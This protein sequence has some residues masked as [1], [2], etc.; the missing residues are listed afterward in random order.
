MSEIE[1]VIQAF[2][3]DVVTVNLAHTT[4]GVINVV[5]GKL[6]TY[7]LFAAPAVAAAKPFLRGAALQNAEHGDLPQVREGSQRTGGD[8]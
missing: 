4:R 1:H 5:G 6:N 7:R 8:N 2:V 3:S